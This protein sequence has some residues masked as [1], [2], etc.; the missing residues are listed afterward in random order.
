VVFC[1]DRAGITGDDGPSHHGVLDMVLLTKVPGMT[2]FAPS[3]YQELQVMFH[4][5]LELTSGPVAIRWPK[6]M[7]RQ[8]AAEEVGHGLHARQVR[9]GDTLCIVSVGKMLEAAETAADALERDGVSVTLWDARV[10]KPL[11][12]DMLSDAARHRYVVTVEDGL[13]EGGVGS[14]VADLLGETCDPAEPPRVR[15]LGV[16]TAY[17]PHGKPDVI[18][19]DLGLDGPGIAAAATSLMHPKAASR[20]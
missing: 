8:V 14:A 3:S 13:R 7:A 9:R 11:D 2:V 19:A 5:A 16:P 6:T 1:I 17:I 12:A 10:V 20:P 4:D 18:L 15:V